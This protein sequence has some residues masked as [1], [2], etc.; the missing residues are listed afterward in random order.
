MYNQM[1]DTEEVK[2]TRNNAGDIAT[3][4]TYSGSP[5]K[6]KDGFKL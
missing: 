5:L 1:F 2:K 3:S 4:Y 6:N